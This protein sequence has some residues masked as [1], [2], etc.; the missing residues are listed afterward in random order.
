MKRFLVMILILALACAG[1]AAASAEPGKLYMHYI[2]GDADYPECH[3]N[4]PRNILLHH[5]ELQDRMEGS[6]VRSVNRDYSNATALKVLKMS[7]KNLSPDGTNVVIAYSHGGQSA[8]FMDMVADR[9]T[10]VYLI[11]ACVGIGGKCSDDRSKGIVWAQW[12]VDTARLGVNVHVFTLIGKPGKPTGAKNALANLEKAAEED[13]TLVALGDGWYQVLDENG[14]TVA[15]IETGL[16]EGTHKTICN[17][18]EDHILEQMY[19]LMGWNR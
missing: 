4:I 18:I 13:D 17:D 9:I 3:N 2:G 19:E 11:D 16:M 1:L 8:Y 7:E 10:D 14:N 15:K 6:Y 5:E 12:F